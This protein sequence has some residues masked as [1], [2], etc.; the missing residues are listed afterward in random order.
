MRVFS[1]EKML[2]RRKR[3]P[4]SAFTNKK[5]STVMHLGIIKKKSSF[6]EDVITVS[7]YSLATYIRWDTQSNGWSAALCVFARW[8]HALRSSC[9]QW[10]IRVTMPLVAWRAFILVLSWTSSKR[11][12]INVW[13]VFPSSRCWQYQRQYLLSLVTDHA[14]NTMKSAFLFSFTTR[15][16]EATNDTAT[17]HNQTKARTPRISFV[18]NNMAAVGVTVCLFLV[19]MVMKT[20]YTEEASE[21]PKR[22]HENVCSCPT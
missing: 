2:P 3:K 21:R 6:A 19:T 8:H 22:L 5:P 12:P 15:S 16:W 9:P 14:R 13:R 18:A 11:G 4:T 1:H 20:L 7:L 17:N 10:C